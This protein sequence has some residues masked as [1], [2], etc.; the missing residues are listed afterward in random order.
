MPQRGFLRRNKLLRQLAALCRQHLHPFEDRPVRT[1]QIQTGEHDGNQRRR[2]KK[3]NLPLHAI[4]DLLDLCR[5]LLLAF[6]IF[7]QQPRHRRAQR[8]LPRLQR[9]SNLLARLLVLALRSERKRSNCEAHALSGYGSPASSMSRIASATEFKSFCNR[10]NCSE[11]LRF[12]S[13]RSLC[14]LRKPESCTVVYAE[15]ATIAASVMISPSR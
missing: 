9:Q 12:R 1:D 2:Q 14:S 8:R 4:I 15:Y 6:I 3:I 7:H 13:T 11:S 5:R 10:S